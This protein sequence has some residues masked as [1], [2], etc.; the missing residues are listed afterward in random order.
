MCNNA[1]IT[2]KWQ[3]YQ[4]LR[5]WAFMTYF[6]PVDGGKEIRADAKSVGR[7]TLLVVLED[8]DAEITAGK[9]WIQITG[10]EEPSPY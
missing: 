10:L 8:K 2:K 4:C 1:R 7:K 9:G 5:S 3:L 6:I